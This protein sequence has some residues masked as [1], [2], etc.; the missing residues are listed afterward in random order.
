MQIFFIISGL[1]LIAGLCGFAVTSFF[2]RENRAGFF[3]LLMTFVFACMWYGTG[4]FLP[5]FTLHL[6]ITV[7]SAIIFGALFFSLPIGKSAPLKIDSSK[8]TRFDERHVIFGRMKLIKGTS[9][10]EEYYQ[11]INP[12]IK[13]FDDNLRSMPPV[14]DPGGTYAHP[15]DSRYFQAVFKYIENF[16]SLADPGQP[17]RDPIRLTPDEATKRV[18]GFTKYLG[19]LDVRITALK[20]YHVYTHTGRRLDDWGQPLE[21][22]HKYAIV[23]SIEMEHQMI[24]SAPLS[25]GSTETAVKYMKIANIGI[26]LAT[27]ISE[28]GYRSRAHIDGNYHILNTALAHDAGIGELGRL[29]LIITP[30]HGPRIRLAAVTTDL[31]LLEDSPINFGV[32]HFCQFCKKCAD[33]CPSGAIDPDEKKQ[34]RGTTK[35]QS[36][37]ESCY[38]YWKKLGTDCTICVTVC[39]YSKPNTFYHRIVRFFSSRN[40][41]A[42]RLALF[43]DDVFYSRSPR[44]TH[45]PNWF[46]DEPGI[47][48]D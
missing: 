4:F 12:G 17:E 26:S 39:P 35:W 2:E 41:L 25:P 27:Y 45:K 20:D 36:N 3:T 13:R 43:M 33:N 22:E 10:Y 18:K 7:W 31:P 14:G 1:F 6:I 19:A 5:A 42:R 21:P 11:K 44:H 15:L 8:I 30:T 48:K 37:M 9:Q 16:N 46:A 38:Q 28:I 40:A 29:G 47:L 24:H 34:I 23:F 32:Q